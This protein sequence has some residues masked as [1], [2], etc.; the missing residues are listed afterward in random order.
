MELNG[1]N[2]IGSAS[3][4]G[5][6]ALFLPSL[7][8]GGAE[9]VMVTLANGFADRGFDVDLVLAQAEGPYV[10]EVN[11]AVRIIDLK[12]RRVLTS[13]PRL[14]E[15]L[16]RERPEAM[17]SAMNHANVVAYLA[18]KLSRQRT[19]LVVSEHVAL[20]AAPTRR[21]S[22]GSVVRA[23]MR[24]TY[25]RCH[26]IVAVSNAAAEDLARHL[27]LSRDRVRAL[28]NPVV[29]DE[30]IERS[31]VPVL[32]LTDLARPIVLAAGRL[33]RQ[34]DYPTLLRAIALLRKNVNATLV[35]L[36]EG[37]ARDELGHLATKLGISDHV[38][39][40][41]FAANP[42]AWM[43]RAD[44]FVVSSAWEGLPTALIEAMACGTPVVSTDCPSGPDE[45]LEGGKWGR[46]VPVGDPGALAQAIDDELA[47]KERP[48]IRLRAARFG[49]NAAVDAY[50]EL[51]LPCLA[52]QSE[53]AYQ[54]NST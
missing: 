41:G 42:Y 34:K 10:S 26:G 47:N 13:L 9:R 50:L 1:L 40:P 24:M 49:V 51:L 2:M 11:Q 53:F 54:S 28:Y 43:R 16:R 33:T 7:R 19:R 8:G 31:Q 29:S 4:V 45:I 22:K 30:L 25:K 21:A 3:K 32:E 36:G 23:L 44:L 52:P 38:V 12:A 5:R 17:L 14:V 37:E 6:I 20:S 46:L 48:D 39:M 18:I 27:R 35:I 15:Y